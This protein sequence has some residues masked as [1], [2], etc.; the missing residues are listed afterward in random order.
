MK[1]LLHNLLSLS[2]NVFGPLI[3]LLAFATATV[4]IP[5]CAQDIWQIDPKS[6]VATLSLGAGAK[7][8]Q[9]GLARVRGQVEFESTDPSDPI[10]TFKIGACSEVAAEYAS[11]SFTS[12]S[13]ALTADG[14]LKV[15]GDLSVIRVERSPT[16]PMPGR[17]TVIR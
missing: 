15:I 8:S 13:S 3:T 7:T 17:S 5:A 2:T 6:S 11:M 1:S 9:I 12:R 10:V 4:S 16:K 14:K